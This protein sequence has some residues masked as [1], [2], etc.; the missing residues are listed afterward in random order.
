MK[1]LRSVT[2]DI[3]LSTALLCFLPLISS[4]LVCY[5]VSMTESKLNYTWGNLAAE[6][7]VV[8]VYDDAMAQYEYKGV[9]LSYK[10]EKISSGMYVRKRPL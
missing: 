10:H 5:L 3:S 4:K 8:G 6:K 2:Q 7:C 9:K 1:L